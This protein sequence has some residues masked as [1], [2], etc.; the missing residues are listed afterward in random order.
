MA[1]RVCEVDGGYRVD[2]DWDGRDAA[3]AFLRHLSGRGFSPAT[4]RAYA[5]DVVNLARFLGEKDV[6]LMVVDA[7]LIFDWIDW[8]QVRGADVD[9]A[10]RPRSAAASTVNRRVAAVRALFEYLVMTERRVDN[11]VPSPR[12]GQ[13]LHRSERGLLGHLG[14]GRPRGGGRLVRQPQQLP[15][16]LSLND[17]EEFMATLRTHRDRAI[18]LAMLLGGLR[19][20]EVRGLLL[21]DVDMGRRRLRVI[22]KGRKERHVPVDAAFFTEVAAYLRWERSPGLATPQCFVVLRGLTAGGPVS[23]AGLRS[24]F[25]RHRDLSG[26]TRV[27][28]HRLRHTYG[29]ELA[30]AG[31]DLLA[32][33]ALMGHTSPETTARYVH[34]SVEQLA[35]EYGAARAT[36]AGAAR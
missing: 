17:I 33:R 32:L 16:S 14:P 20:A 4:V 13:G 36:L 5:F 25:R 27:R 30:S 31:I 28:P 11:P 6:A 23:E 18:V 7:V 1:V 21:A 12:R 3:N 35:A 19:S 24:L 8:Q 15:E 26:A 10:P 29:T 34:L 22:G 2:G 9:S